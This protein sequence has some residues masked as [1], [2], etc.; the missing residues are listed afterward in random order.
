[1]V[2]HSSSA[3]KDSYTPRDC[4]KFIFRADLHLDQGSRANSGREEFGHMISGKEL[5]GSKGFPLRAKG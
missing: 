5:V 3:L 2:T 4:F 1:M